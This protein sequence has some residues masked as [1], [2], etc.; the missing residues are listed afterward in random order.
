MKLNNKDLTPV[1]NQI[2]IQ[3]WDQVREQ[4]RNQINETNQ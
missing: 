4:V 2:Y 3:M 1:K